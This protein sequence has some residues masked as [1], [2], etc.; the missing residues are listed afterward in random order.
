MIINKIVS[1]E[2]P[3][4]LP[5]DRLETALQYMQDWKVSHLP[6]V[7]QGVLLGLLD[8]SAMIGYEGRDAKVSDFQLSPLHVLPQQHIF[9]VIELISTYQLSTIPVADEDRNYLGEISLASVVDYMADLQSVRQEGSILVLEMNDVDYSLSEISR[10]I[11]GND[12]KV[13]SAAVTNFDDSR[14]VEVSLKINQTQIR[15]IVQTLQRYDYTIKAYYDAP[16]Y[17]DDIKKRYDELMRYL[18]I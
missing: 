17:E 15:G 2:L 10:L 6:V 1:Q 3:S 7:E 18:N 16:N 9:E 14:K 8:E 4:L 13:L 11:E 12:A 5:S